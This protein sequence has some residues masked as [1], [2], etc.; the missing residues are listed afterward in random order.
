MACSHPSSADVQHRVL[1]S[2]YASLISIHSD[3]VAAEVPLMSDETSPGFELT[4]ITNLRHHTH[5]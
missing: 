5:D 2:G 4:S 1:S 3:L